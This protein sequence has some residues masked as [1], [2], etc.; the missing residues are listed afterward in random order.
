M[1]LFEVVSRQ[2]G[3]LVAVVDAPWEDLSHPSSVFTA[4]ETVVG[5]GRSECSNPAAERRQDGVVALVAVDT[6]YSTY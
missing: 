1:S 6:L 2:A 4:V 5:R 3:V